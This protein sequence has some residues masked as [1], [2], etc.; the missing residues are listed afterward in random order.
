[1]RKILTILILSFVMV[2]LS[3]NDSDGFL[4]D[5]MVDETTFIS[6]AL[7]NGYEIG[8]NNGSIKGYYANKRDEMWL[9]EYILYGRVYGITNGKVTAETL[10][11]YTPYNN[12]AMK[13]V[14]TLGAQ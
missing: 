5:S 7:K 6:Y 13:L 14:E 4:F 8:L 11:L 3:A 12:V 9:D 2:N 1:M 10:Y